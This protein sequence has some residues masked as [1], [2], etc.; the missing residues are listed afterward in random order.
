LRRGPLTA[1]RALACACAVLLAVPAIASAD[2]TVGGATPTSITGTGCTYTFTGTNGNL[3]ATDADTCIEGSDGLTVIDQSSSNNIDL[4]SLDASSCGGTITIETESGEIQVDAGASVELSGTCT[5]T[6]NASTT[7]SEGVDAAIDVNDLAV[8]SDAGATDLDQSGNEIGTISTVGDSDG[9]NGELT[10]SDGESLAVANVEAANLTLT[11]TGQITEADGG[12]IDTATL[13]TNSDGDTTL[14]GQ[15]Q[16]EGFTADAPDGAVALIDEDPANLNLSGITAGDGFNVTADGD[17]TV[18]D[19]LQTDTGEAELISEGGTVTETGPASIAAPVL[20]AEGDADT[21]STNAGAGDVTLNDENASQTLEGSANYGNFEA[22]LNTETASLGGISAPE[23]FVDVSSDYNDT[24]GSLEV[25]GTVSASSSVTLADT[26]G[27]GSTI[28]ETG[29]GAIEAAMLITSSTGSTTLNTSGSAV[30]NV[31]EFEAAVNNGAV[32]LSDAEALVIEGMNT[33]GGDVGVTASGTIDVQGGM[34]DGGS[35]VSLVSTGGTVYEDGAGI[36][37]ASLSVTAAAGDVTLPGFNT[38][39]ALAVT[40]DDGNVNANVYGTNI[41]LDNIEASGSVSVDN[42]DVDN[43][44]GVGVLQ[45]TGTISGQSIALE[46]VGFT[47]ASGNSALLSA[48]SVSITDD[49]ASDAWT[50]TPS[51]IAA[52][53][54]GAI[55]YSD[56]S[57]LSITGGASFNVT[58][59][60]LT[61]MTFN[62][63][64]PAAATLTYNAGGRVVSGTT[65]AP[66]GTIDATGVEPVN[67][68]GMTAVTV[69]D[70]GTAPPPTTAPPVTTPPTTPTPTPTPTPSSNA[71]TCTLRASS[72]KVALPKKVH[73][74]LKGKAT[75]TFVATCSGAVHTIL[76]AGITVVSKPAHSK[77]KKSKFYPIPG[78]R[79]SLAVDSSTKIVLDVPSGVVTA[80]ST[81]GDTLSARATLA[82]TDNR[83][84]VLKTTTLARLT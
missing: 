63:G 32:D 26:Q 3:D 76:S 28:T 44:D 7:I 13:S 5:L 4:A 50:V 66:S 84:S 83:D 79:A 22:E 39:G 24:G 46:A 75:L 62:G 25:A 16:V 41:G 36:F 11:S 14:N 70:P 55:A 59:S 58:P 10:V 15:N 64:D 19:D 30:N 45:P 61:T 74:K 20:D 48:P 51:M 69:D 68:S 21:L 17:I 73:R 54:T 81:K 78:V 38:V 2:L 6:L 71:P 52:E 1:L 80:L 40:A 35:A 12:T 18:L 31:A 57:S 82:D 56:A 27:G 37:A 60:A 23:G 67:F 29:A 8:H 77:K 72:S 65:T 33:G 47:A 9:V 34:E 42:S 49:D 53:G 43:G